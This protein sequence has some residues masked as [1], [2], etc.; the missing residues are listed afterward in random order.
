MGSD[1]SEGNE[2]E[3]DSAESHT[4]VGRTDRENVAKNRARRRFCNRRCWRGGLTEKR[5]APRVGPVAE[6]VDPFATVRVVRDWAKPLPRSYLNFAGRLVLQAIE[7]IQ[8]IGAFALIA[9]GVAVTKFGTASRVMREQVREHVFSGGLK[10]MP[11]VMFLGFALG[12]V[13]IG[14]AVALM[15]QV[16]V[17]QYA[18]SMMVT[19]VVRE[20]G[21]MITALIVLAR[22]GT[23]NVIELGTARARGEIE[24]LEALTIDPMHY[25]VVPRLIA[26]AISVTALTVYLVITSL[27]SGYLFVF[28]QDVPLLPG[29]YFAQIAGALTWIDF[30][31][32]GLKTVLFGSLIA[33]ITSYEGLARPLHLEE[34]AGA[35]TRAVLISVMACVFV[36]VLF[37]IAYLIVQ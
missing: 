24:A 37:I 33:L 17:T 6:P 23:A 30:I 5:G 4:G 15:T 21:P 29:D 9:F 18:G 16:N 3:G 14:Q 10:L 36:D 22:V 2:P 25:L 1:G 28:V 19:V 11:F 27:L 26:M 34:V 7:T 12:F 8:G 20:L 35:S 32:L 31:L 13:A